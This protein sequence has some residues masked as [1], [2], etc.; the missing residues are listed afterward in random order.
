MSFLKLL[1]ERDITILQKFLQSILTQISSIVSQFIIAINSATGSY[2]RI[3]ENNS[4]WETKIVR[5]M[6]Y[7]IFFNQCGLSV[8]CCGLFCS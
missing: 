8:V 7:T 6:S 3:L 5:A 1:F 2:N 4:S